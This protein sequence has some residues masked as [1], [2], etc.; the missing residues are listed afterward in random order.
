M[1]NATIAEREGGRFVSKLTFIVAA[2]LLPLVAFLGYGTQAAQA[3]T[4]CP[5]T[6]TVCPNALDFGTVVVDDT[7]AK[8]LITIDN[9]DAAVPL[10]IDDVSILGD[11]ADFDVSLA[12]GSPITGPI[13]VAP[14]EITVLAVKFNP[15]VTGTRNAT[16]NLLSSNPLIDL[17]SINLTG[18]CVNNTKPAITKVKPNGRVKDRTP[19]IGATVRDAQTNLAKRNMK[20]SWTASGL[21]SSPTIARRTGS[22]SRRR[23]S[24]RSA[25]TR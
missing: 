1:D 12:D 5:D 13:I 20:R 8:K 21:R 3:T 23:G 17:R 14:G 16:I 6:E 19:A 11:G 9:V 10:V 15:K 18:K 2:L 22:S 4:G 7:S 24:C 25:G